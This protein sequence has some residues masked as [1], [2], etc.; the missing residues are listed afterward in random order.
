MG[1]TVRPMTWIRSSR[2]YGRGKDV[3]HAYASRM[4]VVYIAGAISIAALAMAGWAVVKTAFG[5]DR[6]RR[7]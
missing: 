4:G 7:R 6:D 2:R 3:I 5:E 1:V